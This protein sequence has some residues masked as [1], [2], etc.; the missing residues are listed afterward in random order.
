MSTLT[1]SVFAYPRLLRLQNLDFDC[2]ELLE[3]LCV[4]F[5]PYYYAVVHWYCQFG[6]YHF[7]SLG[8]FVCRHDVG[9][10]DGEKRYIRLQTPHFWNCISVPS[11]VDSD[12]LDS[13]DVAG[14]SVFFGMEYLSGLPELVQIVGWCDV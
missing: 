6:L 5:C 14:L 11:M 12:V 4:L 8:G 2:R 3:L 9:P 7:H 10:A 13:Y 1:F